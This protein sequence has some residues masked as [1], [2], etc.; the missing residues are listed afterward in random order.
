MALD[1]GRGSEIQSPNSQGFTFTFG[2][3]L[4][5]TEH[6]LLLLLE[7]FANAWEHAMIAV[8]YE[9]YETSTFALH[10]Y[11]ERIVCCGPFQREHWRNPWVYKEWSQSYI[12]DMMARKQNSRLATSMRSIC[13]F[14]L[15]NRLE[16]GRLSETPRIHCFLITPGLEASLAAQMS[17]D[18]CPL[19]CAG[20]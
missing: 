8:S 14:L 19:P 10:A 18:H 3:I 13:M 5:G 17:S 7:F 2:C 6:K 15:G 20:V 16:I 1:V 9:S 11:Q 4:W 12:A